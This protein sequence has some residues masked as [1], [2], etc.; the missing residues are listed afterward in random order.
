[1]RSP[2]PWARTSAPSNASARKAQGARAPVFINQLPDDPITRL[3]GW[4]GLFQRREESGAVREVQSRLLPRR[5]D[6]ACDESGGV[7]DGE[8]DAVDVALARDPRDAAR[9]R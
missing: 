5:F 2:G 4:A 1:M 6:R 7:G 8:A 3:I 9:V